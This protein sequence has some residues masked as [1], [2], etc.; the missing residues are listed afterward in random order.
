MNTVSPHQATYYSPQR[1]YYPTQSTVM[2][3]QTSPSTTNTASAIDIM[4][5]ISAM[6]P[7]MMGMLAR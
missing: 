2:P 7:M 4:P 3:A 1:S 6:I 5:V